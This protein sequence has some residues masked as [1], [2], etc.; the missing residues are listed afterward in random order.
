MGCHQVTRDGIIALIVNL[1]GGFVDN[2]ADP[3]GATN[4]G[5]T[6]RYL[7]KARKQRPDLPAQV[8]DLT[9]AQASMLYANDEWLTIHGDGLP[10]MVAL[11]LMDEA[12]NAS[13]V[14]AIMLLQQALGVTVDGIMGPQTLV[15]A[16]N[17]N[18]AKLA[19]EYAARRAVY[20]AK[21]EGNEGMFELGWMRRL[22][23]IYTAAI[24]ETPA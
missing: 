12:V 8:K 21:L 15:A 9:A 7:D 22:I 19:A 11:S 14:R 4:F 10:P 16:A 5:V 13:P 17:A 18:G 24:Q 20:Y 1:E 3:G 2:P 23:T 6:Q